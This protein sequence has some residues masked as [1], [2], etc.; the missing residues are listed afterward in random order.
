MVWSPDPPGAGEDRQ[1][2]D[3]GDLGMIETDYSP[4]NHYAA[5]NVENKRDDYRYI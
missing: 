5:G 3:R 4:C 1:G 2:R